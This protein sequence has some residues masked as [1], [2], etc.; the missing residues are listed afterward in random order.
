[1]KNA[2]VLIV[3]DDERWI[4]TFTMVLDGQV[5]AITSARSVDEAIRL[6]DTRYF[7]V[8]VV[9]LR[10][11][12]NKSPD[13]TGMR[14]L[15]AVQERGLEPVIA[16]IMCTAYGNLNSAVE[17]L[18]DFHVV[19]FLPKKKFQA[20]K[21]GE[22]VV[23]ALERHHCNGAL[24]IEIEGGQPLSSLWEPYEWAQRHDSTELAAELHDLLRRLFR[25]ADRL[26]VRPLVAGQSGAAVLKVEP[27]YGATV[28]GLDIVKFGKR[29]KILTEQKNY[30]DSIDLYISN[31]SSTQLESASGRVMGALRYRLI[32]TGIGEVDSFARF[33]TRHSVADVLA[34]LDNLFKYTCQRWYD[35][36]QQPRCQRN[37]IDLYQDGLHIDWDP[38]WTSAAQAHIDLNAP[39]LQ[40]PGV[41]G[42]L[43]NPRSWLE[44]IGYLYSLPVWLA[45]THGDLNEHN[46]LVTNDGRCW[47]IDFYRT[48]TGHILRDVVELETAVKFSLTQLA[49]NAQRAEFEQLLLAQPDLDTPVPFD[50]SAPYAK[51][52]AVIFYLRSLAADILGLNRDSSEYH[53]ALLL[54][55]LN[56][57]RL[58]FLH[59]AQPERSRTQVLLSAALICQQ[60]SQ[61]Q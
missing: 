12:P 59:Q 51:A 41:A 23:K 32:G 9:D 42:E 50:A 34:A 30:E 24:A 5:A 48:G 3:E 18:R 53:I 26:W 52:A 57:L 8:A 35:N 61:P 4:K 27:T 7:N 37:L 38:I 19:D 45:V 21:L 14:F 17:A 10:L 25:R 36:R 44:Q 40:F 56:L 55:T 54:Q 6:L 46:V 29:E 49:T 43:P 33:Y 60:L 2:R 11:D 58:D 15:R 28:G 47:L 31:L 13:E 16:P 22:A 1:M 39:T 20:Q